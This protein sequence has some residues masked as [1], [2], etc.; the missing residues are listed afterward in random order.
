MVK[1]FYSSWSL[2]VVLFFYRKDGT[3]HSENGRQEETTEIN[4][5]Y[6][7]PLVSADTVVNT[8]VVQTLKNKMLTQFYK[9]GF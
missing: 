4:K 1:S 9:V 6:T 7:A 5:Q 8:I 3:S 2:L